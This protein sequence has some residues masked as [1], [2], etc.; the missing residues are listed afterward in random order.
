MKTVAL[1]MVSMMLSCEIT[2]TFV[3]AGMA[4]PLSEILRHMSPSMPT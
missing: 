4:S 1:V 2:T 3:P